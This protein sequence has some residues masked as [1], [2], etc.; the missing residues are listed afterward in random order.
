VA[1]GASLPH[2]G[3]WPIAMVSKK[4]QAKAGTGHLKALDIDAAATSTA[5]E[6]ESILNNEKILDGE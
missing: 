2:E 5:V 3:S 4:Q 6:V 1:Q